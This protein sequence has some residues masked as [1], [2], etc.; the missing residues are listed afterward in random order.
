[1]SR[2]TLSTGT[3]ADLVLPSD[4]RAPTMG[5]VLW[6]DIGGLRA[7][8]DAHARRLV[9]A[10]G[11]AVCAVELFPGNESMPLAD[12]LAYAGNFSDAH[13]LADAEAAA[14]LLAGHLPAGAPIRVLGF[15]MGGMYSMK[16]LASSRFDRAVAF[17]GMV[18]VPEAWQGSGQGDALD[19]VAANVGNG[20]R[21]GLLCIFGTEDPWCPHAEIDEVEAAGATVVRYEGADHGWA[22]DPDGENYRPADAAD[23]WRRAE[24]YLSGT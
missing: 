22:Q 7:V 17:Y 8:F 2:T 13:K 20:R 15:C 24:D 3:A 11:W 23:A 21:A 16:T 4:G 5:L 6:P 19:V 10:H 1:M 12:R 18:R 9:D 14:D